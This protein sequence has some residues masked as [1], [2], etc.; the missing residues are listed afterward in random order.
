M[1]L[2]HCGFEHLALS[3][4]MW[5]IIEDYYFY[6]FKLY[7]LYYLVTTITCV[8]KATWQGEHLHWDTCI[9]W[10]CS[11]AGKRCPADQNQ[12]RN[13]NTPIKKYLEGITAW[14][15][16][17]Y[18]HFPLSKHYQYTFLVSPVLISPFLHVCDHLNSWE[19]L[20]CGLRFTL[21][22]ITVRIFTHF[23][24]NKLSTTN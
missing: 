3:Y 19:I 18:R 14:C 23:T 16:Q 4:I 8:S 22:S 2:N 11:N 21:L 12:V 6:Y 5:F 24:A 10:L 7:A 17:H 1:E 9:S 13:A 20:F 15:I